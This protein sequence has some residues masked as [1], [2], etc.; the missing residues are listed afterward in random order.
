MAEANGKTI[1]E[2]SAD[3]RAIY[4]RLGKCKV[5]DTVTYDELKKLTS[6]DVQGDDRYVLETALRN[7]LKDGKVFG[8]V[9]AVGVRLLNDEEIIAEAEGVAPRLRRLSR[10]AS[11]KLTAVKD[12]ASLPNEQKVRHNTLL[13]VFG[14]I[15]LMGRES[16]I[17]KVEQ[18]VR[19][20]AQSLS[21]TQTLEAF[22]K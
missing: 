5:G 16:N 4:Q 15:T 22:S 1:A 3:S 9:R 11:R 21:L 13:S 20:T 14:A 10:R 12:F 6:R 17:A 8:C 7:T 19:Q 18:Q 2:M